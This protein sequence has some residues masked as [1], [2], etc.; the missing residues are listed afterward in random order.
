MVELH[1][2]TAG[3]RIPRIRPATGSASDTLRLSGGMVSAS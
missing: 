2:Q 1:Q 3:L